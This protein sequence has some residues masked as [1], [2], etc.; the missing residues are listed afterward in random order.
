M[1]AASPAGSRKLAPVVPA[2]QQQAGAAAGAAAGGGI[3]GRLSKWGQ[4][5][6]NTVGNW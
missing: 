4:A 5:L 3:G 1:G 2:Q 6:T